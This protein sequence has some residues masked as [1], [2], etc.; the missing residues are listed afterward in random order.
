MRRPRSCGKKRSRS[1]RAVRTAPGSSSRLAQAAR[2]EAHPAAA[3]AE[4]DPPV[5]GRAQVV[6]QRAAVGDRLVPRPA[7]LLD[8]VGHRLGDH[9]VARRDAVREPEA[10]EAGRRA[11]HG[12]HAWRRRAR[13]RASVSTALARTRAHGRALVQAHPG[14]DRLRAQ[15]EREA[16]GVDRGRRPHERPRAE[17]RRVAARPHL[18][19]AS[20]DGSPR[21]RRRRRTPRSPRRS[22]RAARR[23]WR[24]R[25]SA[26]RGTRRR[27]PARRRTRRSRGRRAPTR[28]RPRARASS[29]TR[30]RRIGRSSH[31]VETK[32]PFRPLGPC[33]ASPAS[34]TTTSAS[35]SSRFSCQAV[36][37]P[38]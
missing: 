9:H 8:H 27:R 19:G 14:L 11:V 30:S 6:E 18:G 36:H 38:R 12:E 29:P 24:R 26:R 22:A 16:G 34:S 21:A 7:E 3:P 1:S 5:V 15:A 10:G 17:L 37:S 35:G 25:S 31:S 2:A 28:A 20:A 4:R 33:P 32:P 13:A 23:S